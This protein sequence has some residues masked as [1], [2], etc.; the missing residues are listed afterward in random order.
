MIENIESIA[1]D[2]VEL[3]NDSAFI[4]EAHR[5]IDNHIEN[6][7]Q[8]LITAI[9]IQ[10]NKTQKLEFRDLVISETENFLEQFKNEFKQAIAVLSH[11][12]DVENKANLATAMDWYKNINEKITNELYQV[13]TILLN[14]INTLE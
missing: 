13:L 11:L 5:L 3:L 4:I 2:N 12:S 7:K 8:Q 1:Y 14:K 9:A 6:I 10:T